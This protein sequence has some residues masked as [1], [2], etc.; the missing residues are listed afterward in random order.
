MIYIV[1]FF[2]IAFLMIMG[3]AVFVFANR[4]PNVTNVTV[5]PTKVDYSWNAVG[6]RIVEKS[7]ATLLTFGLGA[8][9]A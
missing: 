3:Y 8:V 5:L 4:P 6:K 2:G 9:S 7:A 1:A